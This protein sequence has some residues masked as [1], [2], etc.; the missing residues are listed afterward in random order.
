MTAQEFIQ[1]LPSKVNADALAGVETSFH[2]NLDDGAFK[3]TVKAEGGKI[4][5]LDG[6][7]GEAKCVVSA[8]SD[9]LMKIVSGQENAM[10]AFMMGKIKISN[11]GEMMKYAKMF[12]LM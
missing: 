4:E 1:S 8:K 10:M 12:G 5:V 11:P 2:F 3:K 6:L 9:T 7:I